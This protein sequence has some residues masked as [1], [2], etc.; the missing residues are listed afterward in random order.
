MS[1]GL[2][3][4]HAPQPTMRAIHATCCPDCKR[5]TRMLAFFTPW[6]GW[7]STCLRCGRRWQDGEWMPLPF[8]RGAR[9]RSVEA[10]K[11]RWRRWREPMEAGA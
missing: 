6:Y 8:V 5:R 2:V 7:D 9:G 1:A 11:A 10:S 3:H 4:I